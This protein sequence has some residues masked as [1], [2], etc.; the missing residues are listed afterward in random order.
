MSG[1]VKHAD[2]VRVMHETVAGTQAVYVRA[3]A[4]SDRYWARACAV[5]LLAGVAIGVV[6]GA[7]W[8]R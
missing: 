3:L 7:W 8:W 1:Y 5:C 4:E 6:A 2:A